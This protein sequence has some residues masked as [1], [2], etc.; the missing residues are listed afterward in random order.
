MDSNFIMK[1]TLRSMA[2]IEQLEHA[3]AKTNPSISMK[4]DLPV[5]TSSVQKVVQK[6]A[7]R[8]QIDAGNP[9]ITD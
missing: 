5:S 9:V 6:A 3:D 4:K 1:A 8:E 2:S 7:L